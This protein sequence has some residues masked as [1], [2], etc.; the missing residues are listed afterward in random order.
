MGYHHLR[1]TEPWYPI[2]NWPKTDTQPAL[3]SVL[4]NLSSCF[5]PLQY[6]AG[7]TSSVKDSGVAEAECC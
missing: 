7:V 3:A 1:G 5:V 2:Q 6:F 4:R